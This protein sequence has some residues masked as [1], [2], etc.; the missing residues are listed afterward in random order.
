MFFH[1]EGLD[2]VEREADIGR[3]AMRDADWARERRRESI[4][5]RIVIGASVVT[6]AAGD[7][8]IGL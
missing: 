4:V 3:S 8:I 2:T 7:E 1:P 5:L 6:K